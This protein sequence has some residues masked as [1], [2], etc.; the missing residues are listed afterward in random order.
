MIHQ[1]DT[2]VL[3]SRLA[4]LSYLLVD[5]DGV[6]WRGCTPQPGLADFISFLRKRGIQF[7]LA[8]N[9]ASKTPQNYVERL[10]G[11]GITIAPQQVLTSSLATSLYL[12]EQAP[13]NARVFV[14]GEIGLKAALAE[15]GFECWSDAGSFEELAVSQAADYVVVGWDRDLS[16]RK[17]ARANLLIR[18]GAGFVGTNPDP[19][20]PSEA[21]LLP[22]NGATLAALQAA[23]GVTPVVIG[24]P[25]KLMFDFALKRL[26]AEPSQ[27]AMV[28]D[29]L[30]TDILGGAQAGLLTVL[31]MSGV[32]DQALLAASPVQPDLI[33]ADIAALTQAWQDVLCDHE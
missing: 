3:Q 33:F 18:A 5:M 28:G 32:T 14:I 12:L 17:L 16:W 7:I 29:R 11:Y 4:D 24:K 22:G 15:Q 1:P 6:L 31:L 10:A 26:G 25:S 30:D 19:T 21:G 9:N 8:T 23:S 20:W 27:T 2:A 13:T